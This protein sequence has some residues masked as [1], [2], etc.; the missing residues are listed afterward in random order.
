MAALNLT[1]LE[2][3]GRSRTPLEDIPADLIETVEEAYANTLES[4]DPVGPRYETPSLGS[5]D[6]AE[7][8]LSMARSYAWHRGQGEDAKGRIVVAGNSTKNGNVR[9]R[10]YTFVTDQAE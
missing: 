4:G 10:V 7:V 6:D 9:F 3:G 1:V 5:K 2:G 8:W